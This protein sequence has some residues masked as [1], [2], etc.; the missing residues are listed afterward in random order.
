MDHI[1]IASQSQ[2][3][4]HV[5]SKIDDFFGRF[6]IATLMHQCGMRKHHGHSIRSLT[7]AI[8]TLPFVGKNFF[9]GIVLNDQLP[10]GKDA[11]YELLKGETYNWRR[12]LLALGSRLFG[13]FNR[14]TSDERESVLIIDDSPYDRS[15]S[16]KVELLAR[17]FDHST[18]RFLRGFRMFTICWS[19]GASCLPMDFALLSSSDDQK[20]LC[21]SQKS[22]DKRCCAYQRR[23]EATV[24]AT[25]HLTVMVKRILSMGVSAKYLLMDSWF[26][27]P[28]NIIALA[29][30]I[31]V[32]GMVKKSSRI[33]YRYNGHSLDLQAIYR[34]LAKH[35]GRAKILASTS[36]ML[37][38]SVAAKLVFVRDRR[39][40]DWLALL[41]TDT[42]L[43]DED[44]V[45]IYGKRWDI[46]VFF[47]MAK[48][49]L[50]LAKEIQCRD[51]DALI[52]HT[53]IVFMR[54]MFLAYQCRME[55]DHRTFGDLFYACC[56]EVADITFF[57]ALCR[58]LTLATDR[59]KQLGTFCEKT[60]AAFFDAIMN[61]ALQCVGLSKNKLVIV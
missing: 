52:A 57:E 45:R 38:D 53:S 47:K 23:K 54:Y 6:K 18:G 13:V 39:K 25:A 12:L 5:K 28:A 4:V 7:Q 15:R 40:K 43:A 22:L 48:Q 10:F 17:I 56:D 11:A 32:I 42:D 31:R 35:P 14:L 24:K 29:R 37:N 2:D 46:E 21:D 9:R 26:T 55:T 1:S 3:P 34:R 60:A 8:F 27:M 58:I 49:H 59:L 19:D 36:V 51:F 61:T 50:K 44:I 20:R 16:K 30:H 33:H 41:S